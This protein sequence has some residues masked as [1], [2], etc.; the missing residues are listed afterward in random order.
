MTIFEWLKNAAQK[1][2]RL[3]AELILTHFLQ[4]SD[5]SYL[6]S[7]SDDELTDTTAIDA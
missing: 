4:A 5:R 2:D 3:D 1:I 6:V 7:H